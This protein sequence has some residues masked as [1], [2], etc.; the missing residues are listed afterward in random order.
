MGNMSSKRSPWTG[1]SEND[2]DIAQLQVPYSSA[3]STSFRRNSACR[4]DG[5][6]GFVI[7]VSEGE[8]FE[9]YETSSKNGCETCRFLLGILREVKPE[10]FGQSSTPGVRR[11]VG[12]RAEDEEVGNTNTLIQDVF[13]DVRGVRRVRDKESKIRNAQIQ[14]VFVDLSEAE[15]RI[16]SYQ[17]RLHADSD[18]AFRRIESW[19]QRCLASDE[20]CQNTDAPFMPRRLLNV[21]LGHEPNVRLVENQEP[22]PYV[23]LSYCWGTDLEGVVQTTSVNISDHFKGIRTL[24]LSKTVQDAIAVCR[25]IKMRYL[26]VDALCI[27]QGDTRDFQRESTQMANI[28]AHSTFTIAASEPDSCK[29]GFL[30]PQKYGSASWQRAIDIPLPRFLADP[31]ER[32][33]YVRDAT[34]RQPKRPLKIS[35]DA[36]RSEVSKTHTSFPQHKQCTL[37]TRGWCLQE[38]IL[39]NRVLYFDGNE[40]VWR[41]LQRIYCECGHLWGDMLKSPFPNY[42]ELKTGLGHGAH[43]NCI[44]VKRPFDLYKSWHSVAEDYS[45]RRLTNTTDKLVAISGLATLFSRA[46]HMS[47]PAGLRLSRPVTTSFSENEVNAK[48]GQY[49]AGLWKNRF[50]QDLSWHVH[51]TALALSDRLR[52]VRPAQYCAPTWSWASIDGPISYLYLQRVSRPSHAIKV[53][54]KEHARL[55]EVS[56]TYSDPSNPFGPITSGHA[57][58]SGPI[59]PVQLAVL[60]EHLKSF[61]YDRDGFRKSVRFNPPAIPR[62]E[63]P[64]LVRGSQTH[65][66]EVVLDIEPEPTVTNQSPDVEIWTTSNVYHIDVSDTPYYC[67]QLFSW[68]PKKLEGDALFRR[69]NPYYDPP[70]TP[71]ETWFLLLKRQTAE[72]DGLETFERLGVGHWIDKWDE[73]VVNCQCG[74]FVDA[75][76]RTVKIV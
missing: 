26:W 55:F 28:Y 4:H 2:V 41:C 44:G 71:L 36:A 20:G 60:H 40:I 31:G 13:L 53:A 21:G 61:W 63:T 76:I 10:W 3:D 70:S 33:I 68:I 1:D 38:A 32:P 42:A 17:L 9:D 48:P 22:A 66:F 49:C 73:G 75:P 19:L 23:C 14:D 65:R 45:L 74:L 25:G 16:A 29:K 5:K 11:S 64:C 8:R 54:M 24:S 62:S 6:E 57:L 56:F 15:Q 37:F 30:G 59:I 27:I 67:L 18:M 47:L 50:I 12:L 7:E 46:T 69:A 51:R 52:H 43:E 34:T 72:F 58:L 39:P 35:A